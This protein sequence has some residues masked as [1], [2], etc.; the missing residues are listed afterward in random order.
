MK[1]SFF[2]AM[3]Y[4]K[5][6]S[7]LSVCHFFYNK[8]MNGVELKNIQIITMKRKT[9]KNMTRKFML[10]AILL[11][12]MQASFVQAAEEKEDLEQNEDYKTQQQMIDE[13][14]SFFAPPSSP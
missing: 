9:M 3:Q 7:L 8:N 11:F 12:G 5:R 13:L 14:I 4:K 2:C 10:M 1:P 6:K